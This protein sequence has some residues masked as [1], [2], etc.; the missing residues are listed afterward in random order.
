MPPE[1]ARGDLTAI[2]AHSDVYSLGAILYAML[3]GRPPHSAPS[4][5]ETL[6]QVMEVDAEQRATLLAASEREAAAS[7]REAKNRRTSLFLR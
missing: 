4:M 3:S 1:Q 6:R 7:E 2:G 5:V